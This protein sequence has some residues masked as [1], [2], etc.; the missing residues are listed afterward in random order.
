MLQIGSGKQVLWDDDLLE[1]HAGI[2]FVVNPGQ[3]TGERLL[4][5]DKP[6]EAWVTGVEQAQ[7][8]VFDR[9]DNRRYPLDG[10]WLRWRPDPA[11]TPPK[12]P[13]KWRVV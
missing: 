2:R 11:W 10:S 9:I 8:D 13:E 6:W 4:V 3:R 7:A 12:M 1:S 5:A